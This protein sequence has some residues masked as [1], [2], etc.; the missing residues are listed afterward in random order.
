MMHD[1]TRFLTV[2]DADNFLPGE[3]VWEGALREICSGR[4]ESHWMW[5][6]FPQMKGLGHSFM[7]EHY[8]LSG[9]EEARAYAAHPM[10]GARLREITGA[11]LTL[12]DQP[13]ERILGWTDA[14][15]LRSCMTLFAHAAPEEALFRQVLERYYGGMEDERTLA[16]LQE[17]E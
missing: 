15:K 6:I 7:A 16:L 9:L 4:K 11:L 5:F 10:L 12:P 14:M 3:K 17:A 8:G 13:P 2:Q 1:L